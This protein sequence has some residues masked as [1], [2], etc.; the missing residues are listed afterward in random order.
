VQESD[1][2]VVPYDQAHACIRLQRR[3]GVVRYV[4]L[5]A[6][7]T[8]RLDWLD[9]RQLRFVTD[10]GHAASVTQVLD[11]E[12]LAW[13]N[14]RTDYYFDSRAPSV[15]AVLRGAPSR[16][17]G[18]ML[19]G[20]I[21][22]WAT[23]VSA[24][25]RSLGVTVE[26]FGS[27]AEAEEGWRRSEMRPARPTRRETIGGRRLTWWGDG[28]LLVR[29]GRYVINI[30]ASPPEGVP[31]VMK[32]FEY[33]AP[34]LEALSPPVRAATGDAFQIVKGDGYEGAIVP[35]SSPWHLFYRNGLQFLTTGRPILTG[36][37]YA[38]WTPTPEDI[39]LIERDLT[40]FV[41]TAAAD[42]R[43]VIAMA[44]DE[45]RL[46][47]T[48]QLPWLRA[49]LRTL[50]RQ[51]YGAIVGTSRI[52]LVHGFVAQPTTQWRMEAIIIMDGGCGNVWFEV[53][54]SERR[55]MRIACGA[56]AEPGVARE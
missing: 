26:S 48:S 46:A 33:L 42:P 38:P 53:N 39:V 24:S 17:P 55:V 19:D 35:A 12:T 44:P 18:L 23:D 49:N 41:Q 15:E 13:G 34:Q 51:Y 16:V 31:L 1:V 14:A 9:E 21:Q 32:T 2:L 28:V 43:R 30:V 40:E 52:V 20:E 22:S 27:V 54:L 25:Y 8:L 5:R 4:T 11:V 45:A 56:L 37:G 36:A 50:T 7:R 3:D 47:T 6:F 29:A 10:V